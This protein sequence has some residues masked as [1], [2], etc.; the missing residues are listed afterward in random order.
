MC[1]SLRMSFITAKAEIGQG[2]QIQVRSEDA[3]GKKHMF[4]ATVRWVNV[5]DSVGVLTLTCEIT[6]DL[7]ERPSCRPHPH[8]CFHPL[9]RLLPPALWRAHDAA[10]A[11]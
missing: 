11:R 2:D 1:N 10:L 9:V 4:D 5:E 3:D 8:G 6:G 7:T